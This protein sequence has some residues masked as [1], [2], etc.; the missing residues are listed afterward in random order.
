MTRNLKAF[1]AAGVAMLGLLAGALPAAAEG[2]E[3]KVDPNWP[4]Q[5]PNNW[6]LG[7]IGG[8]LGTTRTTTASPNH[9]QVRSQTWPTLTATALTTARKWERARCAGAS[10]VVAPSCP[11]TS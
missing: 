6:I 4:K 2:P 11:V 10:T 7:Q 1:L 3:Y 9:S 5:F 8:G